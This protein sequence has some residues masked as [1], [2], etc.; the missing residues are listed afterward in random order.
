MAHREPVIRAPGEWLSRSGNLRRSL[1]T[2]LNF[3]LFTTSSA[4]HAPSLGMMCK[5]AAEREESETGCVQLGGI[6]RASAHT[7]L[8]AG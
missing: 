3:A 7:T 5:V 6:V 8:A 1:A 2:M 4:R